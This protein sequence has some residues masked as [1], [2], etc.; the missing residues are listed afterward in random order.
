MRNV[1]PITPIDRIRQIR[2]EAPAIL[3]PDTTSGAISSLQRDNVIKEQQLAERMAQFESYL[4]SEQQPA[5]NGQEQF[6]NTVER[7]RGAME[8]RDNSGSPGQL[9]SFD[10]V[11][12]TIMPQKA[13]VTQRFGNRSSIEAFSGGVNLGTDFAIPKGTPLGLPPGEWV[14][15]RTFTTAKEGNRSA[16]SGSGNLVLVRNAK[17]NETLAFEHLDSVFVAPG[18]VVGGG[19]VIGK[20]GNTGNSTGP[21]ISIPYRN[22]QGA[23]QDILTSPYARYL[24]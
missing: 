2:A 9:Q 16:N 15:E 8:S 4:Q 14:V 21:H 19:T 20:S 11:Q 7:L 23:Y 24:F 10:G 17:T 6:T 5:E 18:Q 3:A 12:Q 1:T 22:A 13:R